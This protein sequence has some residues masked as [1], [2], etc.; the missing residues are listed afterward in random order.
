L[1][2]TYAGSLVVENL[3]KATHGRPTDRRRTSIY[4]KM[5]VTGVLTNNGQIA[6]VAVEFEKKPIQLPGRRR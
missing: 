4:D 3:F 5:E 6:G 2:F 1:V